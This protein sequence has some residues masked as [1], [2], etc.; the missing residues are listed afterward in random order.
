LPPG[1]LLAIVLETIREQQE[2]NNKSDNLVK[3]QYRYENSHL[4]DSRLVLRRRD[5]INFD[6]NNSMMIRIGSVPGLTRREMDFLVGAREHF[7]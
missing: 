4:A 6:E 1:L 3:S 7:A 5:L 2:S